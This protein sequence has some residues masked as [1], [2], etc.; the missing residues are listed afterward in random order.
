[1]DRG[2]EPLSWP[3]EGRRPFSAWGGGC[4]PSPTGPV[5]VF[6]TLCPWPIPTCYG[7]SSPRG[8]FQITPLLCLNTSSFL[9]P[10]QD[11]SAGGLSHWLFPLPKSPFFVP[12]G[13]L[14]LWVG[15]SLKLCLLKGASVARVQGCPCLSLFHP[16][17]HFQQSPCHSLI[18]ITDYCDPRPYT[19]RAP[20]QLHLVMGH[21][22]WTR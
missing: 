11:S 3:P 12:E 17:P 18:V 7:T 4:C 21:R 9:S 20:Q 14:A 16:S 22:R 10:E 5:G 19:H 13:L 6:P 2:P 15:V 1:M 8:R